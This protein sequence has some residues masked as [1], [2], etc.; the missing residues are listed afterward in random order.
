MKNIFL[1]SLLCVTLLYN[2]NCGS[3]Y[4]ESI[5]VK[6]Q[7]SLR[8]LDSIRQV[9]IKDSIYTDSVNRAANIEVKKVELPA[10]VQ[11]KVDSIIR[12]QEEGSFLKAKTDQEIYSMYEAFANKYDPKNKAHQAELIKWSNDRNIRE[13]RLK[14]EWVEKLEK[15]DSL[16]E[17]KK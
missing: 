7:D 9:H 13:M 2:C 12:K 5:D 11:V 14:D 6:S 17:T 4:T 8:I 10:P 15:L 3:G 1:F 16:M